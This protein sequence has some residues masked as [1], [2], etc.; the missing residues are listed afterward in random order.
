[1][2]TVGQRL[3]SHWRRKALYTAAL[4]AY[5]SVF[6]FTLQ[7]YPV[8]EGTVLPPGV[9]DRAVPFMPAA[10][11]LYNSL[12]FLAPIAPWLM[13]DRRE[14]DAYA[15]GMFLIGAIAFAFFFFFPTAMPRT[16]DLSQ[17]NSTYAVLIVVDKELNAFPSLHAAFAVFHGACCH[18]V[19][20]NGSRAGWLQWLVWVWVV[21]IVAATLMTKQ[22][23]LIDAIGGTVLGLGAFAVTVRRA[24]EK[25]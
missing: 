7:R 16:H 22:H 24:S 15:R 14:V 9:I 5:F 18:A 1:M 10:V 13:T 21:G 12:W 23:V 11:H 19:F 3:R 25:D 6:Y 2:D 8:F 17:V 4:T 20:R